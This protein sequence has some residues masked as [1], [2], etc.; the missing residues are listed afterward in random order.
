MLL[1]LCS[2]AADS[3]SRSIIFWHSTIA[4]RSYSACVA[5]KSMRFIV[6]FSRAHGQDKPKAYLMCRLVSHLR[7]WDHEN[8]GVWLVGFGSLRCKTVNSADILLARCSITITGWIT[9]R[10][11]SLRVRALANPA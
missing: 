5:L 8:A 4:T 2:F 10:L 1:F 11:C 6:L 7:S 9:N 3:V